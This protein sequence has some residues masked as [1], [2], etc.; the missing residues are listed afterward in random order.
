MRAWLPVSL[1]VL[2]VVG[3][4]GVLA[5]SRLAEHAPVEQP[6]SPAAAETVEIKRTDLSVS[7]TVN[8]TLGYGAPTVLTGRKAGTVTW[9]PAVG[10]VIDRGQR[11]YAVD[12]KSVP[13]LFGGTPLYRRID[14][15]A[16]PGP[17]IRE[18]IDNLRTLGYRNPGTGNK[19]TVDTESALKRWQKANGLEETGALEAG[20]AVVLPGKVRVESVKAQPGAPAA[21]DVFTYTTVDKAVSAQLD[22]AQVDLGTVK[23]GA[24]VDL[25]LPNGTQAPGTVRSVN[26]AP[27]GENGTP[28]QLA[29]I[30]VDDQNAVTAMDSGPVQVKIVTA[31][32]T[33]VL[34]VPVTALLALGEG[35]YA[36]QVVDG[37]RTKLVGVQTGL[38]AGD[39]VEV[40]GNGLAAGMRV[41]RAS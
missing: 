4:G 3:A 8:G 25:Q 19:F 9:L 14:T 18:L 38:F 35:G 28:K 6:A 40:T 31:G 26:A 23:P 1:A 10:T 33:G 11:L 20:D 34:A 29:T 21:A 32:R 27:A 22:P 2:L 17:D 24:K 36:L 7:V 41:V 16:T 15:A 30:A 5:Y 13:L 37:G 12:A 39:L